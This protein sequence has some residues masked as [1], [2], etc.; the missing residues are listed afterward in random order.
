MKIEPLKIGDTRKTVENIANQMNLQYKD[1]YL[2][3]MSQMTTKANAAVMGFGKTIR[4]VLGDTLVNTFRKDEI[5]VVM[6]HEIAHQK[7]K[8]VYR[9][10][11]FGGIISLISNNV[12]CLFYCHNISSLLS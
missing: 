1:I 9:G 5:E 7:N 11:L 8:D 4:I 2:L 12:F 6:A 10:I 3:K